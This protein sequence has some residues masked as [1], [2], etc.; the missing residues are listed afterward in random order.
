MTKAGTNF[1][2]FIPAFDWNFWLRLVLLHVV[3]NA[4]RAVTSLNP[5]VLPA[6]RTPPFNRLW[7]SQ[8]YPW[9]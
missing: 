7:S 9:M 4:T 3:K 1:L 5:R 8:Q 2:T 6:V